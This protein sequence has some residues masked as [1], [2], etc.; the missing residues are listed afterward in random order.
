MANT[1]L[2]TN[3]NADLLDG[4]HATDFAYGTNGVA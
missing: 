2:V 3:M 1:S 4:R